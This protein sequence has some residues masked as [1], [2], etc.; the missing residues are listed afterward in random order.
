MLVSAAS[1]W[2]AGAVLSA[3]HSSCCPTQELTTCAATVGM[4]TGAFGAH[5]LRKRPGIVPDKIHAW[6]TAAQYSVRCSL[7]PACPGPTCAP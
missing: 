1:L 7:P 4:I 6:E 2:R 5:G 3:L